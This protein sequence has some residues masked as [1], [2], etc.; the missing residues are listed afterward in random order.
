M[1]AEGMENYELPKALITRVAKAALPPNA[2]F[3]KDT[4]LAL[5]RG[6]S[7]F[8]NFLAATAQDV[9]HSKSH[10]TIATTDVTKA[11][12]LMDLNDILNRLHADLEGYRQDQKS[13]NKGRG[14]RPSAAAAAPAQPPTT[15][16]PIAP[17]YL[18]APVRQPQDYSAPIMPA[19]FPPNYADPNGNYPPAAVD[20]RM[21]GQGPDGEEEAYDF[22]DEEGDMEYGGQGGYEKSEFL[23]Q[24]GGSG[25]GAG[26]MPP[27]LPP[28]TVPVPAPMP[29]QK[30]YHHP[31]A[32]RDEVFAHLA[33]K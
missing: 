2:K 11:L 12:E 29:V 17:T 14:S 1:E 13:G 22:P 26:A 31:Q 18:L 3:S 9:A 28:A 16:M 27:P 32:V 33:E 30:V 4:V 21:F 6:S 24:P 5:T 7:V 19:P 8:I 23:E 15:T 10:K 20:P 25:V